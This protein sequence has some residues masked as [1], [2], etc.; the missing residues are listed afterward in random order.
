[1]FQGQTWYLAL[2][3]QPGSASLMQNPG[4]FEGYLHF[5]SAFDGQALARAKFGGA[6][7]SADPVVIANR[8]Y[9]Q[10]DDGSVGAFEII[11]DRPS[12]QAPD[13]ADDAAADST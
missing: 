6:A 12:R 2:T 1:M 4:D 8:L 5:F 13:V 7:I 10:S 11:P 3:G 9:V